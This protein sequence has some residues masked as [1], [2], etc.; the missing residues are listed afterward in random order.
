MFDVSAAQSQKVYLSPRV[1]L[2]NDAAEVC[3]YFEYGM[4]MQDGDL[5]K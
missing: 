2:A 1:L 3:I 4:A 5:C